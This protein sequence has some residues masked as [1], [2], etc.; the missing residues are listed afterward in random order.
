M[1][2]IR[3]QDIREP[4]AALWR[5]QDPFACAA[6]LSGK[7]YRAVKNRRTLRFEEDGKGYFIKYHGPTSVRELLK[8]LF[9]LR[10]PVFGAENEY[11]A[12]RK[13]ESLGVPT[14]TI[15]ALSFSSSPKAS[16]AA[17]NI[18]GLGLSSPTSWDMIQAAKMW[19]RP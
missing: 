9:Q 14:M 5:G 8:N 11:R 15:R 10:M 4:F 6:S 7:V 13:L 1:A 2:E 19:D 12:I 17:S 18:R 16:M 3:V